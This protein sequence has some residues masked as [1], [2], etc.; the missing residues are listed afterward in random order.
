VPVSVPVITSDEARR[1]HTDDIYQVARFG[2][3]EAFAPVIALNPEAL[4]KRDHLRT[5]GHMPLSLAVLSREAKHVTLMLEALKTLDYLRPDVLDAPG[6][7][8]HCALSIAIDI[9]GQRQA[10]ELLEAGASPLLPM[11][12]AGQGLLRLLR[13]FSSPTADN[14]AEYALRKARPYILNLLLQWDERDAAKRQSRRYNFDVAQLTT[15]AQ[16]LG[17]AVNT[18]EVRDVLET[19]AARR[20][21]V[22]RL[23]ARRRES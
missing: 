21:A 7:D 2:P 19:A 9:N 15:L 11:P 8:G 4:I 12:R 23:A 6:I 18:P 22:R 1:Y 20:R 3:V 14:A 5:G 13:P 17:N 16:S 10:L